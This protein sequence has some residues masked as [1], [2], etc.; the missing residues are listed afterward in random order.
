LKVGDRIKQTKIVPVKW[1]PDN[2]DSDWD[3]VP[4][5]R[6]CQPFNPNKQDDNLA[7]AKRYLQKVIKDKSKKSMQDFRRF[8]DSLDAKE[9]DKIL[10]NDEIY[11]LIS[12]I[13]DKKILP[14]IDTALI[15]K[16]LRM[17]DVLVIF[18][19][20]RFLIYNS[21]TIPTI[22]VNITPVVQQQLSPKSKLCADT[23]ITPNIDSILPIIIN[24]KIILLIYFHI[25]YT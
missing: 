15:I 7:I 17:G 21:P 25:Y 20:L 22:D 16:M 24:N 12:Y 14:E 13:L 19:S 8:V 6:D 11:D 23:I 9:R 5:Y 10:T 18:H 3:G 2:H 1:I 4:N